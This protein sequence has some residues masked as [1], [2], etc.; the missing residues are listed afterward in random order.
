VKNAFRNALPRERGEPSVWAAAGMFVAILLAVILVLYV[1]A[2]LLQP[3]SGDNGTRS[4]MRFFV[5]A[6]KQLG[7]GW[8]DR[9]LLRMAARQSGL[10]QPTVLLFTPELWRR[11]A[12][13]WA[14]SLAFAPL[15]LM[16]R[17]RFR[18]L[19]E[20]VFPSS[21]DERAP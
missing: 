2:R 5:Y 11:H 19:A 7:I 1:I 18:A 4:P 13:Q 14:E 3:G 12:G 6:L 15:R 17:E 16:A 20:K 8:T 21:S 9:L 10:A